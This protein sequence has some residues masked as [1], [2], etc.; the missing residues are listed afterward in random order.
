MGRLKGKVAIITGAG[1]GFGRAAAIEFAKQGAKVVVADVDKINGETTVNQIQDAGGDALYVKVDVAKSDEV[2]HMVQTTVK[3]YGKLDVLFN[4]AGIQGDVKWDIAH[5]PEE[6]FDKYIAV[7]LKGVWLGIHHAT[8]ELVKSKGVIIN[9]ASAAASL[10]IY[11]NTHYG[12]SKAA[13]VNLTMTVANELGRFGV[14]CNS[15]S[16]YIADTPGTAMD[17]ANKA[18]SLRGNP[19]GKLIDPNDIAQTAVFLASD[20]THCISGANIMIDAAATVLSQPMDE[21]LFF[22]ENTY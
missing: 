18:R 2:K 9:M 22:S 16:P 7:N 19:M 12:P 10:G 4:N 20:E 6:L 13:V 1:S 3:E 5:M 15:I 17:D 8:P 11:G 14:R 21:D